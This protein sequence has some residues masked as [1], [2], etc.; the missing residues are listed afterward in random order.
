[1]PS[2]QNMSS[3]SNPKKRTKK[4]LI[5][6]ESSGKTMK[7]TIWRDGLLETNRVLMIIIVDTTGKP[8]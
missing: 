6:R 7:R 2:L 4:D 8:L 1:M 5:K 3:S